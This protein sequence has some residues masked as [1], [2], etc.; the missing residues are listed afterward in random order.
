MRSGSA[1]VR[2]ALALGLLAL[3][4]AARGPEGSP[5]RAGLWP[6]WSGDAYAWAGAR[7]SRALGPFVHWEETG[8]ERRLELRP[9]VSTRR[10]AELDRVD[11]LYPVAA[12]RATPD[13]HQSRLFWLARTRSELDGER[14]E[15]TFGLAFRGRTREGSGYGGLFPLR[16]TFRERFGFDRL[17]FS[18]WPLFARGER[19]S[20]VETQILWPF[21]AFGSGDGDFKLRVWPLFGVER[22]SGVFE[23]RFWLWPFFHARRD[24]LDTARPER[25]W[26]A[27]PFYGRRDRGAL[28]TR[29]Y[30]FPLAARQ[31]HARRDDVFRVDLLWPIFSRARAGDRRLL[32]LRPLWLAQSSGA[33]SRWSLLLHLAGRATH[34]TTHL[35]ESLEERWTYALWFGRFGERTEG[36]RTQRRAELWPLF[37]R[38]SVREHGRER[39]FARVPWLLPVKGLEPDGWDRHWNKLFELYG[40]GPSGAAGSPFTTGPSAESPSRDPR[41]GVRSPTRSEGARSGP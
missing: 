16:G 7:E 18:L 6:L 3:G 40:A 41:A 26:Y 30:L 14:E 25:S 11:L 27:V 17:R 15:V 2:A 5:F 34:R 20:Y 28:H 23:H 22:R 24:H 19:G 4:C 37:R 29:F 32:A 36:A 33:G 12:R 39:G 10:S 13:R 21:F 8:S 1:R 38:Y 31:W 35:E 9:L